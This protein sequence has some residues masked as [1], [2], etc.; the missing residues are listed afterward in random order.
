[1]DA[2]SQARLQEVHPELAKRVAS[3]FEQC[4]AQGI[5]LRVTQGLRTWPQQAALYAQ[6]RTAPGEIVTN[7]EPGYSAHNFGYAV[8]V[9]PSENAP[10]APFVPDWSSMDA[11]WQQV[12][13]IGT[14]CG[15]GEGAAWRTFP[16]RPHLYLHEMPAD[17]DDNLRSL[18]AGGGLSAV[19]DYISSQ[20][21]T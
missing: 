19:F 14:M 13:T 7:A 9:A 3:L 16:D 18:L 5:E 15:L 11:R 20:V 8:D 1:M 6:G 2:I 10:M 21:Q 4:E 17:P 12:L